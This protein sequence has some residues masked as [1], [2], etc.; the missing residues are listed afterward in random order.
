MPHHFIFNLYDLPLHLRSDITACDTCIFYLI[1]IQYSLATLLY[2][3][4]FRSNATS[5][6]LL[7]Q[8]IPSLLFSNNK[9]SSLAS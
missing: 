5:L 1:Y 9:S 2:V 3:L 8:V 7:A 4:D 6:K